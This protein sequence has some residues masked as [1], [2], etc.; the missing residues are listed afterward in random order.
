MSES[1]E[2]LVDVVVLALVQGLTEF[3][4]VSSSGHLVLS[5]EVLG[6]QA[7]GVALEIVLHLG[8]LCAV[9]LYYAGDWARLVRGSWLYLRG[10]RASRAREAFTTTRNLVVATLPAA[11]FGVLLGGRIEAAFQ[12]PVFVSG[13]LV[14]TAALLLSTRAVTRRGGP[15][16]AWSALAVGLFQM[17]ALFP[18]VSRSG[19][20]IAG[21]MFAGVRPEEAARFSFLLSVPIIIGAAVFKAPEL[22]DGLRDGQT[23]PYLLGLIVSFVSGYL[24]IGVLLRI[25]R[26]G[27][28]SFFGIYC[29]IVGIF[30]LVWF[31]WR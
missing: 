2:G 16:T 6:V 4:P 7:P 21:G 25:V 17:L 13:S 22:A 8:T 27:R 12:S 11:L 28:F 18:G 29:L 9:V 19:S 14:F 31:S 5:Q 26:R 24:A 10:S 3:L 1:A 23:G 30:G 20:T 15:V